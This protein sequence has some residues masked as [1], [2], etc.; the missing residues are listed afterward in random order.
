MRLAL[1]ALGLLAV[2]CGPAGTSSNSRLDGANARPQSSAAPTVVAT[3]IPAAATALPAS[4]L[5][6]APLATTVVASTPVP[7][8]VASTPVPTVAPTV[9]VATLAPTVAPTVRPATPAPTA[10]AGFDPLRYIGQGDAYNC[11]DFG[12]QAQAQAVLRADPRDPN[13]LDADNDG[14]ACESNRAPKDLVPVVR[15]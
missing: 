8:V 3:T 12:S 5:S 10:V 7:A 14:I 2:A 11:G 13:R 4:L 1:I 15:R 6:V 9:R